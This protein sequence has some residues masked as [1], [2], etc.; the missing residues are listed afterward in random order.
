VSTQA[1]ERLGAPTINKSC[2]VPS[3]GSVCWAAA[4]ACILCRRVDCAATCRL[5]RA[6]GSSCSNSSRQHECAVRGLCRAAS[7]VWQQAGG[8]TCLCVFSSGSC[9]MAFG[10]AALLAAE[11]VL[12]APSGLRSHWLLSALC[13]PM[14]STALATTSVLHTCSSQMCKICKSRYMCSRIHRHP[15]TSVPAAAG[16]P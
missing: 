13:Y 5:L 2:G 9:G 10:R 3:A 16:S 12:H 1:L 4:R 15:P 6:A 11:Q 14:P 7:A 8:A